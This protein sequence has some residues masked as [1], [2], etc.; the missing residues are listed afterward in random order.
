MKLKFFKDCSFIFSVIKN[1]T[2]ISIYNIYHINK[3]F[4]IIFL[5]FLVYNMTISLINKTN[6]QFICLCVIGKR[7]NL[8]AKEYINHYKNLGYN[9]IFIYDNN[10][11]IGERFSDIL[12]NEIKNG[13]V[14]VIDFIGYK[15]NSPST[16]I[17]AYYDC[18]KKNHKNYNW[19]SFYDFDEFLEL[20]PKNI[21]IQEFLNSRRYKNCQNIK[22]NWLVYNSYN[23][24]LYYEDK[25]LQI[26]F[27]KAFYNLTSNM[28]IKSTVRG[29]INKNYWSKWTNPHSSLI[30]FRSCSSSGEFVNSQTPF[31]DP[32]DYKYAFIK[33]Y[34]KKSF[35]EFC[36]KIKR[37]WP[38]L[39]DKDY[40][41]NILIK[42]NSNNT[43][44]IEIIKRVFNSSSV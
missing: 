9:H 14:S 29:G 31:I 32:P 27:D 22:I 1:I 23:E 38:D 21:T 30:K 2:Y 7:E 17:E 33:H 11:I 18:Y 16:Q 5:I 42:E 6:K 40:I 24:T 10:D 20:K 37:G 8:Y 28:H 25:P 39:T 13:F 35:E 12:R 44:K 36:L 41:K 3:I 34:Y 19:L 43:V 15:R 4:K 26:R